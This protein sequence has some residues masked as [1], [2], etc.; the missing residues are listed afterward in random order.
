[1]CCVSLQKINDDVRAR[2]DS[3]RWI[4]QTCDACLHLSSE[5]STEYCANIPDNE[6]MPPCPNRTRGHALSAFCGG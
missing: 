6:K 4:C 3:L 5:K 1:M 2:I